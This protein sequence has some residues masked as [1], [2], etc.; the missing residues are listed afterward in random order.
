MNAL[1]HASCHVSFRL[2]LGTILKF[3][4][5]PQAWND[6]LRPDRRTRC[7]HR[8]PATARRPGAG[9][10]A[11]TIGARWHIELIF[12][13]LKS[14]YRLHELPTRKA[15][16]TEILLLGAVITVLLSRRSLR[17]V[18]E[19]LRHTGDKMPEQRW[20]AIFAA[21]APTI[22]DIIVLPSRGSNV[23]ARR[24]E[25]MLSNEAPDP[26]RPRKQILERVESGAA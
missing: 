11:A 12:K 17:A 26:N 3:P 5:Y 4:A 8:R 22:L 21:A 9:A 1:S 20:A 18:Q 10:R 25:S 16:I 2:Q 14:H 24:L 19:R 15:H 13:E 7:T 23:I 6:C